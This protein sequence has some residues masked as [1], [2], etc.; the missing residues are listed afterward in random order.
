[1]GNTYTYK[2]RIGPW[3]LVATINANF[4]VSDQLPA[5][6]KLIE[7]F[8]VAVVLPDATTAE[9]SAYLSFG[10]RMVADQ[11]HTLSEG[12]FSVVR[13]QQF[14]A[15][16]LTDYQPEAAAA[17]MLEWLIRNLGLRRPEYEVEFDREKNRYV[18]HWGSLPE[19][20]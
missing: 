8:N 16:V 7:G 20:L 17:A 3:G 10:V 2:K 5:D 1:M 9:D 19:R 6:A 14:D 18:F 11:L 15:P 4:T 13:V 12:I